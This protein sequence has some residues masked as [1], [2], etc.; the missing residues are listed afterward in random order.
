MNGVAPGRRV[1]ERVLVR[2]SGRS[3]ERDLATVVVI[4]SARQAYFESDTPIGETASAAV[5]QQ[6]FEQLKVARDV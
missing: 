5:A 2:K 6:V 4:D 1:T 3:P